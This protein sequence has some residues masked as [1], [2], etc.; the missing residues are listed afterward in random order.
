MYGGA[1]SYADRP[2]ERTERPL[3]EL[4]RCK[5]CGRCT[6]RPLRHSFT[7]PL[8]QS[9]NRSWVGSGE[10]SWVVAPS[11]SEHAPTE[12]GGSSF[13]S[14]DCLYSFLF[15]QVRSRLQRLPLRPPA[16]PQPQARD[17]LGVAAGVQ[18]GACP[19]GSSPPDAFAVR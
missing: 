5:N 1:A 17:V 3:T 19:P 6:S 16:R 11:S 14:G 12:L 10:G 8:D 7:A 4:A 18:P 15:S 2:T 13:C 9:K